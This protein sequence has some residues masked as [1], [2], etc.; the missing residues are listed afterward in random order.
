VFLNVATGFKS[1]GFNG[2]FL[3]F[4][5]GVTE[6]DVP[7][8]PEELL[9]YELGIKSTLADG[10]IRLNATLFYYDYK[11]YQA[12]SISGLSQFINNSDATVSGTDIEFIWLP[13]ENWDINLGASFINSEVD[14]VI[15]RGVGSVKNSEMVQAPNFS[16]NGLIRYQAT[17]QLSMQV[18]FNH[19]GEQY[20]D[21]TNSD[22]S[23][24]EAYTVFN[25][26]VGYAISENLTVSAF[27]KNLTEEEYR[28]YNFDFTAM[29]GY[30]Q[31]FYGKPRW[32]G[33][34]VHYS[35]E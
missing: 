9:S 5:D 24:E 35:F 27:I 7:F 25:A 16:L 33:V 28:V 1:G 3:D 32:A 17:E 22:V 18:D 20:F 31:N 8:E 26:R 13:G 14:E 6:A 23:K 34:S 2:G 11:D 19:V 15:V 29:T 21:I 30:A 10:D 4:T 12:L